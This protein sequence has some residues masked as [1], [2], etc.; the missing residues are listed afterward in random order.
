MLNNKQ[1][2]NKHQNE[3]VR[4]EMKK[5][6]T[7]WN[8]KSFFTG[9][10]LEKNTG[11]RQIPSDKTST[12]Q[13]LFICCYIMKRQELNSDVFWQDW[14]SQFSH[15]SEKRMI[16]KQQINLDADGRKVDR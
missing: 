6:P 5:F 3:A 8:F 2:Q 14:N 13:D 16:L 10:K 9:V 15:R 12:Q 4:H 11:R 7:E 1:K